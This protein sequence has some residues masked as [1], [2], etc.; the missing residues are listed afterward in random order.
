MG[1]NRLSASVSLVL[2]LVL[3]LPSRAFAYGDPSGGFLFQMLTPLAAVFW[4]AWLILA[5]RV[6]KRFRK[7]VH[8]LGLTAHDEEGSKEER[9]QEEN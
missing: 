4:G 7:I 1:K 3:S 9:T 6:R 8:R 5:G 2:L